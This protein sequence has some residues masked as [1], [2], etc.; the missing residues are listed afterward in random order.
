MTN[1]QVRSVDEMDTNATLRRRQLLMPSERR[2]R[3][4][5]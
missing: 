1:G 3:P 2:L 4:V 5:L